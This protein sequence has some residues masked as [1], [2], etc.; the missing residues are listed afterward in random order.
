MP[1]RRA[2]RSPLRRL[3][4]GARGRPQR[5]V[6]DALMSAAVIVL[7]RRLRKAARS[8]GAA[9]AGA[10]APAADTGGPASGGAPGGGPDSLPA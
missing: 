7:E 5:A 3:A 2:S 8:G 1:G 9:G 4:A 6:L 10:S